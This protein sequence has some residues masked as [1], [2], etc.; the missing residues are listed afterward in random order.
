[1]DE[2]I[3]SDT[4]KNTPIILRPQWRINIKAESQKIICLRNCRKEKQFV[5]RRWKDVRVGDFVKVVCNETIPADLLLLHTSDPNCVCHIETANLDGETN[6]KQRRAV[7]RICI[8]VRQRHSFISSSSFLPVLPRLFPATD[9]LH[10]STVTLQICF[11]HGDRQKHIL[12]I[13]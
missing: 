4:Q 8:S 9:F 12:T 1:M 7:P 6:L 3:F 2:S 13:A 11:S 10:T 5:E